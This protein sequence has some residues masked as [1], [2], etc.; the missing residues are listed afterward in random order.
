MATVA[1]S[2]KAQWPFR[3]RR[4]ASEAWCWGHK[5]VIGPLS[6][7]SHQ[8]FVRHLTIYDTAVLSSLCL[9]TS[10]EYSLAGLKLCKQGIQH[11]LHFYFLT[12]FVS[13]SPNTS[14]WGRRGH[15]H[16]RWHSTGD[17]MSKKPHPSLPSPGS[18]V[19]RMTNT[20]LSLAGTN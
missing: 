2:L 6:S 13:E 16:Q 17:L 14:Q 4:V 19:R 1:R 15:Q 20:S 10:F 18:P 8:Q 12:S 7:E 11:L 3:P 9:D 5:S